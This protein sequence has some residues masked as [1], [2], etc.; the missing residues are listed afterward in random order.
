LA[1]GGSDREQQL[2]ALTRQSPGAGDPI[3]FA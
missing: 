3:T 2:V 1:G